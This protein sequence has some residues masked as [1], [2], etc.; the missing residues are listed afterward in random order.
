MVDRR[1][2]LAAGFGLALARRVQPFLGEPR[3]HEQRGR[4]VIDG[5][6]EIHLD[7]DMALIDEIRASGMRGCVVTVGNPAL[8]GASAFDDMR[9][10]ID[11]YDRHVAAHPDRFLRALSVADID[12]AVAQG[13]IGL[14]YYTQNATPIQ[15]DVERLKTLYDLGVR[16]AQLT[17]NTRNLLGDGCLERT[18]AGLSRFGIEVVERM[19]A[20]RMLVDLS[21]CGEATTLDGIATSR[22]PVA[23]THAGCKAVYDHPRNKTDE[24]LRRLADRGGVIGIYQI[25]PYLGPR[26]RNTLDDYLRHVDHAI[27]VAGI[28]H[29]GIGS[30]REHRTIPDTEEEK[31]KLIEELS[32]LRPVTAATFRWPFFIAE[33]NHPRRMETI[34]DGLARRGRTSAEIDKILGGNW[35]R[36]FRETIG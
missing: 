26:E 25:N 1:G 30:D 5:L 35:Y 11:G 36:L 7:Y 18:N 33:L 2:F 23:V 13:K 34:A 12:R 27:N 8:H 17:Y 14:V 31:Q 28:E 9:G 15:D 16:I 4:L 21:H 6:G 29:V 3:W 24:A 20:L 32:R 10:E 19:N 22:A